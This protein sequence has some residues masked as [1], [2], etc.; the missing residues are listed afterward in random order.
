MKTETHTVTI[1]IEDYNELLLTKN[2]IGITK[3]DEKSPM[4]EAIRTVAYQQ[5]KEQIN[6]S[7]VSIGDPMKGIE[8]FIRIS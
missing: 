1:P 7:S 4:F 6:F 8:I 5:N 3:L 2:L